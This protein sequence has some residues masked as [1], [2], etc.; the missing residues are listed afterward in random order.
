[1]TGQPMARAMADLLERGEREHGFVPDPASAIT[2]PDRA[3]HVL[4]VG[5]H[6]I[7]FS[8]HGADSG[9]GNWPA[10]AALANLAASRA[11]FEKKESNVLLHIGD[12]EEQHDP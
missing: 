12:V 7:P 1:V 6:T 8:S 5:E 11:W 10:H 3:P 9:N 2:L 4:P